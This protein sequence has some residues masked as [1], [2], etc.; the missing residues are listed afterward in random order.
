MNQNFFAALGRAAQEDMLRECDL[1]EREAGDVAIPD[2]VESEILELARKHEKKQLNKKRNR[3]IRRFSKTAAAIV[4][5][6]T[7]SFTALIVNADAWRG[8][9][10]SFIF[11]DSDAY[12]KIIPVETGGS[13]EKEQNNLPGDWEDVYYPDYLPEGYRFAEAASA[14]NARTISFQNNED[15]L[16]LSQEPSEGAEVLIDKEG[17]ENGETEV[18][19]STAFWSSKGGETT[20]MWNEYGLLFML[21][22]PMDL[23]E[24]KKVAEHLLYIE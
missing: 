10:F 16:I 24:L 18:Q 4:L 14:G 13:G 19:G 17:T 8:K 9:V 2:K 21:Y 22:G 15:I 6:I 5:L 23:N 12:M 3:Y 1:W 20:L 11:Q 7:V